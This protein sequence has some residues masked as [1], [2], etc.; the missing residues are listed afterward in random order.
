MTLDQL[1]AFVAIVEHGSIR[2]AARHLGIAQSGLTQQLH[3]LE[4]SLSATLFTRASTGVLL[5]PQGDTLLARARIILGE[6]HRTEQEFDYLRGRLS[7][8]INVGASAEASA[9]LLPVALR[10]LRWAHPDV[11]VNLASGP[12]SLLLSGIREGRLD[13][14]MT[15]VSHGSDMSDL[16]SVK[17]ADSQA[18]VLCRRGHPLQRAG[19]IHALDQAEWINTRPLGRAGTPSNRLGDWFEQ[20]GLAQPRVALTVESLLDTLKLVAETDY[21]FLGPAFV[22]EEGF[23]GA[24]AAVQLREPLPGAEICLVQRQAVPL[25]PAARV[26][27]SMLMTYNRGPG[28][29]RRT[30]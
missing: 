30:R 5:T 2:A 28:T 23:G 27:A 26:F 4:R 8:S 24:L 20:N 1:R 25:A 17:L 3:R 21:L 7:G 29:R 15:L 10:Q 6:C 14:A 13:F 9:R 22:L 12:S 11:A 16:S 18:C 19:S